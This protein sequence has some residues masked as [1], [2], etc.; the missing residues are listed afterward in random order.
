MQH[1][2][3]ILLLP[4]FFIFTVHAEYYSNMLIFKRVSQEVGLVILNQELHPSEPIA[5]NIETMIVDM[6]TWTS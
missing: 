5:I 4:F 6:P 2:V 3:K 1:F